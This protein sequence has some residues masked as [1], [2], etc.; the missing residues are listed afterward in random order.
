M[1]L[2]IIDGYLR[3]N[4]FNKKILKLFRQIH[5]GIFIKNA[6]NCAAAAAHAGIV[7]SNFIEGF[8]YF[9]DIT[10]TKGPD[11]TNFFAH[12]NTIKCGLQEYSTFSVWQ[13]VTSEIL[14]KI[15]NLFFT[16]FFQFLIKK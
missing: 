8:F 9:L 7:S 4:F 10:F 5:L 2:K 16:T 6:K 15:K 1:Q 13:W 3:L 11:I 12:N 14:R